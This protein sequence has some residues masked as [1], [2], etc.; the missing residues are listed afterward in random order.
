MGGNGCLAN[1]RPGESHRY[2]TSPIVL[3]LE[4]MKAKLATLTERKEN[5]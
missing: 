1:F 4:Q 5:K 2:I 3:T